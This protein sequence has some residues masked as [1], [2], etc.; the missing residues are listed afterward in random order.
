MLVGLAWYLAPAVDVQWLLRRLRVLFRLYVVGSL[1][2]ALLVPSWALESDYADSFLPGVHVRLHGLAPHAN[3]LA[4][5]L[6]LGLITD[7]WDGS[8]GRSS[9]VWRAAGIVALLLTQ[10][11][12]TL[13]AAAAVIGVELFRRSRGQDRGQRL[14]ADATILGLAVLVGWFVWLGIGLA[15]AAPASAVRSLH[16]LQAR[17]DVWDVTLGLWQQNPLFGYGPQLWGTDMRL[18]YLPQLGWAPPHAHNQLVQ[19]LGEAGLMGALGLTVYVAALVGAGWRMAGITNGVSLGVVV[20]MLVRSLTECPIARA[21]G[22]LLLPFAAYIILL[23]ALRVR[24]DG[25]PLRHEERV[26]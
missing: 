8:A 10:S 9:R 2:A 6:V 22:D 21:G 11:K 13:L 24:R 20:L 1:T 7:R 14:A 17:S 4:P 3:L 19:T 23:T 15:E 25:P 16:T 12:T 5:I 26:P 18:D